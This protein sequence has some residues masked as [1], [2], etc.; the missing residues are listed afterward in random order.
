M[1]AWYKPDSRQKLIRRADAFAAAR[2]RDPEAMPKLIAILERPPRRTTGA[3]QRPRHLTGFAADP[4]V[5]PGLERALT[6]PEPLVRAIAALR[7]TPRRLTA[8]RVIAEL[9]QTLGRLLR[10][11]ANRRYGDAGQ[12]WIHDLAGEDG[13]RFESQAALPR[14]RRTQYR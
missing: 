6:D 8:R 14:S 7:I 11:G 13:Q 2:A 9:T 12:S 3:G 5:F 10:R 1:N 4:R